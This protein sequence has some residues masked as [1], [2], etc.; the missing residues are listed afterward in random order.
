MGRLTS[1]TYDVPAGV[2]GLD[3]EK[4]GRVAHG[5]GRLGQ[6]HVDLVAARGLVPQAPQLRMKGLAPV[7]L[8]EDQLYDRSPALQ[9]LS[10]QAI[11]PHTAGMRVAVGDFVLDRGTRQLL[12][13][14]EERHVVAQ[15]RQAARCRVSSGATASSR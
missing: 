8:G 5:E 13:G 7:V 15:I 3:A 6:L 9:L 1:G 4:A 11:P 12:C 2:G 14:G 10:R